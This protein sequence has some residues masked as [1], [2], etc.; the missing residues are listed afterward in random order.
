MYLVKWHLTRFVCNC[1][2]CTM[3]TTIIINDYNYYCL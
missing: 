1:L 3:I 2:Y